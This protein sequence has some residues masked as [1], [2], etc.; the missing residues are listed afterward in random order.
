MFVLT[1]KNRPV[2]GSFV[3]VRKSWR[4]TQW[5]IIFF[6][7]FSMLLTLMARET[8]K[9]T[10]LLKRAKKLGLPPPP[11]PFPTAASKAKFLLTVT[12]VRPLHSTCFYYRLYSHPLPSLNL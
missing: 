4:W 12:L 11:S 8:Y 5:T 9:K 10:I 3:T 6:A 2:L 1:M 7:I